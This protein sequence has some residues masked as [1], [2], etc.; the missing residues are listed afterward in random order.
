MLSLSKEN[1]AMIRAAGIGFDG[2]SYSHFENAI[3]ARLQ[4]LLDS[5]VVHQI[6]KNHIRA[7]CTQELAAGN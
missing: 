7:A 3:I 2:D 6:S 5:G 1:K 4:A